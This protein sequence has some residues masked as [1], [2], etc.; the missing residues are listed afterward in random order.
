MTLWVLLL[1]PATLLAAVELLLLQKQ[2]RLLLL[3]Q[4]HRQFLVRHVSGAAVAVAMPDVGA[5]PGVAGPVAEP[6][7]AA[8]SAAP[9]TPPACSNEG[10]IYVDAAGRCTFAN[11]AA[12]KILHWSRDDVS[13]RDLLAGGD[14]ESAELLASIE[15][16]GLVEQHTT[17]LAGPSA[18]PLEINAVA[19]R[20]RDDNHWGAALFIHPRR[21]HPPTA[22]SPH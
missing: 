18:Q 7:T 14:Q 6:T 8:A 19:L 11:Q 3:D 22:P 16:Q 12:R 5:I 1:A 9:S 13:L 10:V 17:S 4:Q 2:R 20:D 21:D 15:Q